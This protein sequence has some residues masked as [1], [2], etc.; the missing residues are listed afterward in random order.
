MRHPSAAVGEVAGTAAEGLLEIVIIV[1]RDVTV[2]SPPLRHSKD[3]DIPYS[4]ISASICN[5]SSDVLLL[6]VATARTAA[7]VTASAE[8]VAE[9]FLPQYCLV[10]VAT[11][12]RPSRAPLAVVPVERFVRS[13]APWPA[14]VE[15]IGATPRGPGVPR[16]PAIKSFCDT[17][18]EDS[19]EG[20]GAG[21]AVILL[22]SLIR[23]AP[24]SD[25]GVQ[26][27]AK[28]IGASKRSL[29][30]QVDIS[31][32]YLPG[33]STHLRFLYM[34][35]ESYGPELHVWRPPKAS[36]DRST[37]AAL[38]HISGGLAKGRPG[39]AAAVAVGQS[40][41]KKAVLPGVPKDGTQPN[42]IDVQRCESMFGKGKEDAVKLRSL[43]YGLRWPAIA[44]SVRWLQCHDQCYCWHSVGRYRHCMQGAPQRRPR[45]D[46]RFRK[47]GRQRGGGTY[48]GRNGG[49]KGEAER[50][51]EGSSYT[52]P[53]ILIGSSTATKE[54]ATLF[55]EA[56]TG[57]G[58]A[59]VRRDGGC[60][61]SRCSNCCCHRLPPVGFGYHQH[62]SPVEPLRCDG[63]RR[64]FSIRKD[65]KTHSQK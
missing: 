31:P 36:T 47:C 12:L 13:R 25:S 64:D 30:K 23:R 24:D 33:R 21:A 20:A 61:Y 11:I 59:F 35:A 9:V 39:G 2:A 7:A 40:A 49:P 32:P 15:S 22:R 43:R 1:V 48:G 42:I 17:A 57:R 28:D 45:L 14:G 56:L 38:R 52:R 51:D 55:L 34:I 26:S 46:W 65:S 50:K 58:E 6:C 4:N 62:A 54:H 29:P 27:K 10:A 8:G 63:H 37:V 19:G 60:C 41:I 53:I 44:D 5:T 18:D 16:V 3:G